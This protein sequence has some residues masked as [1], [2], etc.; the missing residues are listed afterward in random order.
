MIA[1]VQ[2]AAYCASAVG[3]GTMFV[4]WWRLKEEDRPR[5]WPLYGW[6]SGLMCVGSVF[7]AVAWSVWMQFLLARFSSFVSGVT[8]GVTHAQTQSLLEQQNNLE[9]AFFIPYAIDFVCLTVA[10]LMV[11]ERMA[12]FALAKADGMSRR[13]AVGGRIVMASVVVGHVV[14]VSSSVAVAVFLT[15]SAS[16]YSASNAAYAANITNDSINLG[17]QARQKNSAGLNAASVQQ[18]SIVVVLLIVIFAF[19]VVGIASARRVSSALRH[20]NDQHGAAGRQLRRQI[21]GTTAFVFVTFL[22][23]AVFEGM[24]AL[25][26][27]LQNPGA[28]CAVTASSA[29]DSTC[30]NQWRL[31]DVWI[32]LVPEYQA[33]VI[34]ISSPVAMIVA[35]WGMTSKRALRLMKSSGKQPAAAR[36][37]SEQIPVVPMGVHR[38]RKGKVITMVE[39]AV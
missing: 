16:L 14:I 23:R 25:A 21:I 15:E 28:E 19:A 11:L 35:L 33:M 8:L 26:R 38:G 12:D 5:V 24:F 1:R 3:S 34:L 2:V 9:A 37:D 30:F 4:R 29:C 10:K 22:L 13:L 39:T 7:G 31:M 36:D 17:H 27:A 20:M 6:F 18:F 32:I